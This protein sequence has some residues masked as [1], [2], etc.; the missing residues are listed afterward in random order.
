MNKYSYKF[1]CTCP[2]NQKN[3]QYSLTIETEEMIMVEKL[4]QHI[5]NHCSEGFHE[6]IA[7][8]LFC[9][10]G[11][12]QKLVANHHGVLIETYRK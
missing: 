9:S 3:I 11:G 5:K 2:V 7:D 12:L 6:N 8:D 4:T 10:F 1:K